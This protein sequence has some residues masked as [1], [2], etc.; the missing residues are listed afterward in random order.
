MPPDIATTPRAP[1]GAYLAAPPWAR[2]AVLE[3]WRPDPDKHELVLLDELDRLA[4]RAYPL[5][6]PAFKALDDDGRWRH[7]CAR[8]GLAGRAAA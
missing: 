1:D 4:A 7:Y 2:E 5:H 3:F 8:R 6:D